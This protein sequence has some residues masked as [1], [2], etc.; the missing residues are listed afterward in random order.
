M[1]TPIAFKISGRAAAEA[2]T[3][4]IDAEAVSQHA[5]QPPSVDGMP[6]VVIVRHA[7][8]ITRIAAGVFDAKDI[9]AV[10]DGDYARATLIVVPS[11]ESSSNIEEGASWRTGDEEFIEAVRASAPH[12]VELASTTIAA[13]RAAG[14]PGQLEESPGGRWVNKPVNAFTIK[15]QPRVANLRFTLYG[16]PESYE[17]G[18][19]LKR[20][21]NSYSRGLVFNADDANRLADLASKAHARRAPTAASTPRAARAIGVKG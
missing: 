2:F 8:V 19:F 13:I 12:L 5:T 1:E 21:Q 14:V 9:L 4:T 17:T 6:A 7:E 15:A 18:N 10:V 16:N 20:D 3:V 11:D